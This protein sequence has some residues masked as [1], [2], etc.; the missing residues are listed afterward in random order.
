M[1]KPPPR[2][3]SFLLRVVPVANAFATSK[4]P[5]HQ[6]QRVSPSGCPFLLRHFSSSLTLR[7][8]RNK[9]P[10][11]SSFNAIFSLVLYVA[12]SWQQLRPA[13][14]HLCPPIPSSITPFFSLVP[15]VAISW[16]VCRWLGRQPFRPAGGHLCPPYPS[17]LRPFFDPSSTLL[18]NAPNH[19][20]TSHLYIWQL[21]T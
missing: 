1:R 3:N 10:F 2:T 11:F 5:H 15:C 12:I 17:L 8:H 20:K 14:G 7:C 19:H 4:A 9:T 21:N 18:R 13:G 16:L 6:Q